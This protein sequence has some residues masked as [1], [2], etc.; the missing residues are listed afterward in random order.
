VIEKNGTPIS[1][2][3]GSTSNTLTN[4]PNCSPYKIQGYLSGA[5]ASTSVVSTDT[6]QVK[7]TSQVTITD[8]FSD[9][10]NTRLENTLGV[11]GS[12]DVAGLDDCV[13]ISS[14]NVNMTNTVSRTLGSL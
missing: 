9:N 7:L 8:P 6:I 2:T 10:C 11:V 14:G 13:V 5:T 12:F 1:I 4:R 3:P